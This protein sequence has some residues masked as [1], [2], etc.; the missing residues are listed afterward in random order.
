MSTIGFVG[1]GSM[2]AAKSA[3]EPGIP[4]PAASAADVVLTR[5]EEMGYGH[6]D[7]AGFF[8]VLCTWT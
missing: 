5:A 3:R 6:R 4:L 2:G 1:L 8:Q 7:I